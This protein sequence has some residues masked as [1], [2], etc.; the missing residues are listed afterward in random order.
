MILITFNQQS[1]ES[2][3]K[4]RTK[5][6]V[7]IGRLETYPTDMVKKKIVSNWMYIIWEDLSW[8]DDGEFVVE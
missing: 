7:V 1:P 6:S 8:E 4:S 2:N 5:S 3:L